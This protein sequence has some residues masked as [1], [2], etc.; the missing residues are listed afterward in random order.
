MRIPRIY[1]PAPLAVG[2][3]LD[4]S[5]DAAHHLSRVLRMTTDAPLELFDGSNQVFS[6]RLSRVD[7]KPSRPEC[8]RYA[9]KI[10]NRRCICTWGR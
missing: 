8:C 9:R 5:E 3:V 1:H 2:D 7:K 4:V 6:A 10:A